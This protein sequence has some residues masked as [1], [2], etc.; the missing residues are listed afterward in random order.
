MRGRR[1][2]RKAKN[3]RTKG[4]GGVGIGG[5]WGNSARG[6]GLCMGKKN[7]SLRTRECQWVLFPSLQ[8][9]LLSKNWGILSRHLD[10][11]ISSIGNVPLAPP[12]D[13]ATLQNIG[14]MRRTRVR[15]GD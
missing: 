14:A 11:G 2:G 1:G 8:R 3:R 4:M 13:L 15:D 6:T 7:R 9:E 12:T 10:N 5:R